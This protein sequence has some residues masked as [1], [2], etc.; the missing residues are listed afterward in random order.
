M[1]AWIRFLK[2]K[3]ITNNFNLFKWERS[4][5]GDDLTMVGWNVARRRSDLSLLCFINHHSFV[6]FDK[7]ILE[8]SSWSDIFCNNSSA[9]HPYISVV[10]CSLCS[11]EQEN[12][13]Y[14]WMCILVE[15]CVQGGMEY[16]AS[17]EPHLLVQYFA[18][19]S[20]IHGI[21]GAL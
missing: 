12:M 5:E 17:W 20:M 8:N 2:T 21:A 18:W 16:F 11:I 4:C 15:N 7:N 14:I 1:N 13:F 10:C 9:I 19:D 6:F 3:Q